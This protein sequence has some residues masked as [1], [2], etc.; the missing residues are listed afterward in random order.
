MQKGGVLAWQGGD[1][2]H[3]SVLISTS[4]PYPLPHPLH[5]WVAHLIKEL[6]PSGARLDGELQLCIH[7]GDTDIDLQPEHG[8]V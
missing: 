8:Q 5:I 6:F 3:Q 1:Y 7:G 4:L 2:Q